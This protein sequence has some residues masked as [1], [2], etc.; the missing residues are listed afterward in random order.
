MA[1]IHVNC[2]MLVENYLSGSDSSA[3]K[4]ESRKETNMAAVSDCFLEAR[5]RMRKAVAVN[6]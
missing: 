5:I 2:R 6:Y 4:N 1:K 3:L